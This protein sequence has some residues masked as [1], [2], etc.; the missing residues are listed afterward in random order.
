[1]LR[2]WI[3]CLL[4]AFAYTEDEHNIRKRQ[5][6]DFIDFVYNILDG[7]PLSSCFQCPWIQSTIDCC[8]FLP[9]G[10]PEWQTTRCSPGL[11][12]NP[13]VCNCD[14]P[15]NVPL[16]NPGR[17]CISLQEPG[18]PLQTPTPA[19]S[20]PLNLAEDECCLPRVGQFYKKINLTHY[21]I[22]NGLIQGCPPGQEFSEFDCC[23]EGHAVL[24]NP[25]KF[26]TFD[27][28][29]G[30][31]Y[32]DIKQQ[33][34][35][36]SI[37]AEIGIGVD[38]EGKGLHMNPNTMMTIPFF[39]GAHLGKKFSIAIWVK[40]DSNNIGSAVISNG[41]RLNDPTVLLIM[42]GNSIA[43]GIATQD[44]EFMDALDLPLT[45]MGGDGWHFVAM[46]YN[47][48]ILSFYIDDQPAIQYRNG[49]PILSNYCQLNIGGVLFPELNVDN[50]GICDFDW[51]EAQVA[52][53]QS[54]KNIPTD[55]QFTVRG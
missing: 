53:F 45:S 21:R 43:G 22:N 20:C 13:D 17:D 31:E 11:A 37:R 48:P 24:P 47:D 7:M 29:V 1:M 36:Q 19:P 50:L 33:T 9:L 4:V 10:G 3:L 51:T 23:C 5:A 2:G 41:N 12:W 52:E 25:C 27:R 8:H 34:Y 49:G 38:D 35:G 6:P 55:Q 15:E 39:A 16:C 28:K 14:Y 44:E 30:E 42:V 32:I 18:V 26:W 54:T 46:V 40:S